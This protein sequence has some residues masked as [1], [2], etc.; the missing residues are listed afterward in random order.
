MEDEIAKDIHGERKVFV[1]DFDVEADAFFCGEGIHV[2]AMESTWRAISSAE[3]VSVPLNTMCSMKWEIPLNSEPSS[4][5]P[6]LSQMPMATERMWDI[7]SVMTVRPFAGL[8]D[9][10]CGFLLP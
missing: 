3:R 1:Q 10:C 7:C 2:A 4:R 6:D 5:E 8:D 9:E